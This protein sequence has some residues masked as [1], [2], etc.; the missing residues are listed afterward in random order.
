MQVELIGCTSA[1]KSTL[2]QRMLNRAHT[3]GIKL[4]TSYDFVLAHYG[5][6]WVK[7]HAMRMAL[8]NNLALWRCLQSAG[9]HWGLLR[10]VFGVLRTLPPA[11]SRGERLKIARIT[12]RN[13]GIHEIIAQA[14]DPDLVILADEGA[15]QVVHYLFVHVQTPPALDQLS[16]Y[17]QRAPRPDL[18]LYY[19]QPATVL[20]ER[21]L[22]RGHKRIPERSQEKVERF[23]GHA[24][25]VFET[26]V[27]EPAI[28][29]RT[30]I[31]NG[32]SQQIEYSPAAEGQTG[33]IE[34]AALA[35]L[36]ARLLAEETEQMQPAT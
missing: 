16:A 10:F 2:T 19:R 15:L 33:S 31:V 17:L 6:G 28:R 21:T 26:V 36:V 13:L 30:L 27:A 22:R 12:L 34:K 1:G 20:I 3:A 32:Q 25:Q 18:V 14:N 29:Q 24:R 5:L 7:P 8:L 4:S 9:C 11:I 35:H 23:I